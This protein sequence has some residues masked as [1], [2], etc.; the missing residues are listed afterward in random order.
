VTE[1]VS[2]WD[3][4]TEIAR[5]HF[6]FAIIHQYSSP[7]TY[8]AFTQQPI[9]EGKNVAKLHRY[10]EKR[11][12]RRIPIALTEWNT[13]KRSRVRGIGTALIL[14][15]KIISYLEG[16]VDMACFWPL[17]LGGKDSAF[18]AM[19][20]IKTNE[21]RP[22]YFV[23]RLFAAHAG[24]RIVAHTA[25]SRYVRALATRTDGRVCLFLVNKYPEPGGMHVSVE[26]KAA[27]SR[28]VSLAGSTEA[29]AEFER[30]K[31]SVER[32]GKAWNIYLPPYSVTLIEFNK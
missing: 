10:F 18:R 30:R 25:S 16:G 26:M 4:V 7:Y 31:V 23:M 21:P 28:A 13:S 22:E 20:D 19:L 12:G 1:G 17:R 8:E 32:N 15:E 11:L 29:A 2:W 3:T 14:S 9:T 6:D 5:G 24:E 27:T